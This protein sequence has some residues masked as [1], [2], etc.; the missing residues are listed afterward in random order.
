MNSEKEFFDLISQLVEEHKREKG[1]HN[2]DIAELLGV[3]HSFIK[4][5]HS[6][7]SGRKYSLKQ[8]AILAHHWKLNIE[9]FIP[10]PKTLKKLPAYN[11]YTEE[12]LKAFCEDLYSRLAFEVIKEGENYEIS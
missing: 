11:L 4:K 1:L 12:K 6:S 3:S 10:S 8:L 2:V 7:S 9:D 5:I